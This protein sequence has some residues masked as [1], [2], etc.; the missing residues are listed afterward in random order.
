M[1]ICLTI[2]G[3]EEN[4]TMETQYFLYF[5]KY[6][7]FDRQYPPDLRPVTNIAF[8]DIFREKDATTL[9]LC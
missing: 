5:N 1:K 2:K 3:E 7:Y 9:T 6:H 8:T 4:R